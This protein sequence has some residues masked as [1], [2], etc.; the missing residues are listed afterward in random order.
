LTRVE[1]DGVEQRDGAFDIAA[2]GE[3]SGVRVTISYG[4]AVIRGQLKI[5]GRALP[6]GARFSVRLKRAASDSTRPDWSTEADDRNRFLFEDLPPG[7]YELTVTGYVDVP[8]VPASRLPEVS[9]RVTVSNDG[10]IEITIVIDLNAK[11]N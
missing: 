7:D 9:R 5:T 11:D 1:R 4:T 6:L 8:G 10:E 2:G 3:V